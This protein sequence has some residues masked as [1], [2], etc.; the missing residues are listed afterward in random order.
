MLTLLGDS[1]MFICFEPLKK[2]FTDTFCCILILFDMLRTLFSLFISVRHLAQNVF[3]YVGFS[4]LEALE[5]PLFA[6]NCVKQ[7][8]KL[9]NGGSAEYASS[10]LEPFSAWSEWR[11]LKNITKWPFHPVIDK[12]SFGGNFRFDRERSLLD[13]M[14]G[15]KLPHTCDLNIFDT[16]KHEMDHKWSFSHHK[17]TYPAYVSSILSSFWFGCTWTSKPSFST[18]L[19]AVLLSKSTLISSKGSD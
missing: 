5:I 1:S 17:T 18:F 13:E 2:I 15:W 6:L 10:L 16:W 11:H 8:R 12:R 4:L 7:G 19:S 3:V 9:Q 14:D